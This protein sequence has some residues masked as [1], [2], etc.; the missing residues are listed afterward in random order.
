MS[1]DMVCE[2]CGAKLKLITR[3]YK[4]LSPYGDERLCM[5]TRQCKRCKKIYRFNCKFIVESQNL[6]NSNNFL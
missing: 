4:S 2:K 3:D 1:T 5:E 6:D